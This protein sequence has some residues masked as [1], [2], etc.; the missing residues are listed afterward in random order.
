MSGLFGDFGGDNQGVAGHIADLD[1]VPDLHGVVADEGPFVGPEQRLGEADHAAPFSIRGADDL[2][3]FA[4]QGFPRHA[5]PGLVHHAGFHDQK[6]ERGQKGREHGPE[7]KLRGE[8]HARRDPEQPAHQ[9]TAQTKPEDGETGDEDL[10]DDQDHAENEPMP[11]LEVHGFS[12][13]W[14]RSLALFWKWYQARARKSS[15][16]FFGPLS[17]GRGGEIRVRPV[18]GDFGLCGFRE[19]H[20]RRRCRLSLWRGAVA[21]AWAA[22]GNE[23]YLLQNYASRVG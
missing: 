9:Q 7:Q 3:G 1:P 2:A 12:E 16:G 4:Q 23:R 19:G 20:I 14:A 11:I 13:C 21:M 8:S 22:P 17:A 15:A 5:G 6:P 18:L 10:G